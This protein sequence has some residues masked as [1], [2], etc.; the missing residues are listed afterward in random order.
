[1]NFKRNFKAANVS[2]MAAPRCADGYFYPNAWIDV[3]TAIFRE[4]PDRPNGP[5]WHQV[6]DDDAI[7]AMDDDIREQ[8]WFKLI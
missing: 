6:S 1:M 2:R 4:T 5:D 3:Q 8:V 7:E